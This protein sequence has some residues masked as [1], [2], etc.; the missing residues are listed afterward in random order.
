[1]DTEAAMISWAKLEFHAESKCL[2][3]RW[4]PAVVVSGSDGAL[5]TAGNVLDVW[6]GSFW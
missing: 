4:I 2:G 3:V 5:L 6:K 1:M